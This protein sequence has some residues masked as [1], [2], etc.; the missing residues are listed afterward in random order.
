MSATDEF[1]KVLEADGIR[2]LTFGG[3]TT[4]VPIDD[5]LTWSFGDMYNGFLT[6]R[7]SQQLSPPSAEGLLGLTRM[8]S[9]CDEDGVG[10]SW[11]RYCGRTVNRDFRYCPGCGRRFIDG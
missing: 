11:C 2:Y 3:Y 1:R 7:I 6:A 8:E 5:G 4:L 9:R 10:R